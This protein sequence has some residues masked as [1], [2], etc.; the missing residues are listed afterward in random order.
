[1]DMPD[2]DPE[3]DD[4]DGQSHT[5]D[6]ENRPTMIHSCASECPWPLTL[7]SNSFLRL[8]VITSKLP[9]S[10]TAL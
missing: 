8:R 10:R 3:D 7:A 4:E 6:I 1:M 5:Q 2:A 9:D